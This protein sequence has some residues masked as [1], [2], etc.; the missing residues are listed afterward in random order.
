MLT[1][2]QPLT[3]AQQTHVHLL[4]AQSVQSLKVFL[5]AIHYWASV[6]EPHTSTFNIELVHVCGMSWPVQ[7]VQ[8]IW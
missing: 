8:L 1:V 4:V 6:S 7:P 5:L 2:T 3:H